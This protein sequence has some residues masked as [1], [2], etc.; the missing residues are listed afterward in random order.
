MVDSSKTLCVQALYTCITLA[1]MCDEGDNVALWTMGRPLHCLTPE[2]KAIINSEI[3][4]V[5][6]WA[7]FQ[8]ACYMLLVAYLHLASR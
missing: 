4:K 6:S 5:S 1:A 8:T 7:L 3:C 2:V